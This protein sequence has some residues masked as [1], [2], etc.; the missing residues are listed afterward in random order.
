MQKT[1]K[2][3]RL[4]YRCFRNS[5]HIQAEE[6]P[7][8]P[9]TERAK[10]N[11]LYFDLEISKSL[12]YSYGRRVHGEYLRSADLVHEYFV[13]CWAA[14]YVDG[15]KVFSACVTPE[16]ARN[17]TDAEILAPLHDLMSAAEVVAGHNVNAFDLKKINTRFISNGWQP[18]TGREGM[19][20]KTVDTLTIARTK[21]AFESN[22]LDFLCQK[23]G[24]NGKD[25]I[26]DD[27]WR[28]ILKTGDQKTLDKI[29]KYCRGDVRNGKKLYN[30]LAP[31]AGNKVDWGALVTTKEGL[32][33]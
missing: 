14:S 19:K 25:K 1:T 27:D 32:L 22:E 5:K 31:F 24:I 4:L 29:N 3:G 23:F 26:T 12:Y 9:V 21:F 33:K 28:E 10:P 18:I 20:K 16:Q 2:D 8:P 13:I 11:V 15:S 6:Y 7:F 30:I 17:W